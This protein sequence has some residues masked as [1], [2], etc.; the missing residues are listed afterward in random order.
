M[1]NKNLP[2]KK[3]ETTNQKS[4][5]YPNFHKQILRNKEHPVFCHAFLG[6][7]NP[8]NPTAS[9]W[10]SSASVV[11]ARCGGPDLGLVAPVMT[12]K[13]EAPAIQINPGEVWKGFPPV[14]GDVSSVIFLSMLVNSPREKSTWLKWHPHFFGRLHYLLGHFQKCWLRGQN[15]I[16]LKAV[17]IKVIPLQS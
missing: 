1:P 14:K 12:P 13:W 3:M 4:S 9:S 5:K 15:V 17:I 2:A 6:P 8:S 16:H 7:P 11:V 10:R